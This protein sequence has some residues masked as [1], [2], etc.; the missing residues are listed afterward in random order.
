MELRHEQYFALMKEREELFAKTDSFPLVTDLKTI[1]DYER[2]TGNKIGVLYGYGSPFYMLV[3]DLIDGKREKYT[4]SRI[5]YPNKS[6]G[7]V[8]IPY[9]IKNGE[10]LF[11]LLGI[12]RHPIRGTTGPEFPRGFANEGCSD[13]EDALREVSEEF[14]LKHGNDVKSMTFLGKM[15]AD[16][17]LSSGTASVFLAE[18][19]NAD[20]NVC[21]DEEGINNL[22]FL[23]ESEILKYISENTIK[24][25]FTLSAFMMYLTKKNDL[26]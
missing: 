7:S 26:K 17:G 4:Y 5:V 22:F 2:A 24:D 14:K 6:N 8:I 18:I 21:N 9:I 19:T 23:S 16:A 25:G 12:C 13:A 20:T 3:V 11:G 1:M 10:K 15:N